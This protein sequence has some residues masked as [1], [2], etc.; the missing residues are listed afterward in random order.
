[1]LAK[2]G[3]GLAGERLIA[4]LSDCVRPAKTHQRPYG[5]SRRGLWQ[6]LDRNGGTGG[7]LGPQADGTPRYKARMVDVNKLPPD[8]VERR[9]IVAERKRLFGGNG[10][11]R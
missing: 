3:S 6:R 8:E 2:P 11:Q 10:R 5:E 7:K 9:K 4:R 1:L